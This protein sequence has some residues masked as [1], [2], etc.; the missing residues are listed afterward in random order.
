MEAF[1]GEIYLVLVDLF[2][3]LGILA[4]SQLE[5]TPNTELVSSSS[6]AL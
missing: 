3:V 4:M 2:L 6:D 1:V 5:E